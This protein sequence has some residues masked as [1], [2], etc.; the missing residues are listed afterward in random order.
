MC[1]PIVAMRGVPRKGG[2]AVTA[3]AQMTSIATTAY[4]VTDRRNALVIAARRVSIHA[5][6]K[7]AMRIPISA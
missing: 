3:V 1:C 4:T 6:A 2:L 5:Q 7:T